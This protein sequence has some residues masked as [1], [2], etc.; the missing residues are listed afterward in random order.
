MGEVQKS[1]NLN[2]MKIDTREITRYLRAFTGCLS[3]L[4]H[5][6]FNSSEIRRR[7]LYLC[8]FSFDK[9]RDKRCKE[10]HTYFIFFFFFFLLLL[11]LLFITFIHD[12]CNYVHERNRVSRT[13]SVAAICSY[14]LCYV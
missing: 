6:L 13:Y 8:F 1:L 14:N 11:L 2:L 3:I 10:Y 9:L 4:S 7:R 5:L 12:I